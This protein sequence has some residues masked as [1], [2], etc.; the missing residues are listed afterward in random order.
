ME[1]IC[2]WIDG[3]KNLKNVF[4]TLNAQYTCEH[5]YDED[6]K[7]LKLSIKKKKDYYNIFPDN[8]NLITI[9]GANGCGKSSII[10]AITAIL[11]NNT[12][13]ECEYCLIMKNGNDFIYKKSDNITIKNHN[14]QVRKIKI[15]TVNGYPDG[16]VCK[17]L[18]F[19]PFLEE[20]FTGDTKFYNS[21]DEEFKIQDQINNYFFYDRFQESTVAFTISRGLNHLKK[22]SI[23]QGEYKNILFEK[24]GWEFNVKDCYNHMVLRLRKYLRDTQSNNFP[25]SF[26]IVL[27]N[28]QTYY[29]FYELVNRIKFF[30]S[31]KYDWKP[32]SVKIEDTVQEIIFF[33]GICQF[34][35]FVDYVEKCL[36]H[37]Y[38]QEFEAN[39]KN[40]IKLGEID[41]RKSAMIEEI[42]EQ[43]LSGIKETQP[44]EASLIAK[45]ITVISDKNLKYNTIINV[46]K[47]KKYFIYELN[48]IKN[49][50]ENP[51]ILFDVLNK[52]FYIENFTY[53]INHK[54]RPLIENFLDNEIYDENTDDFS[55]IYINKYEKRI[56]NEAI[57]AICKILPQNFTSHY[58]HINLYKYTDDVTC[59]TFKDM[60]T[61]EQRLIKFFAD[62]FYCNPR[63]I[64][65]I[66]EIDMSWHP[67]WYRKLIFSILEVFSAEKF[68]GKFINIILTTHS[69]IPLSDLPANNIISLKKSPK[70]SC[71]E[72]Y[73]GLNKTFAANIHTL[74]ANQFFLES[75]I[76]EYA[77]NKIKS[78]I[79][80]LSDDKDKHETDKGQNNLNLKNLS[81]RDCK[82]YIEIIGE[83]VYK[84]IL[85]NLY[86]RYT[87]KKG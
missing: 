62:I 58:F 48:K 24:F 86:K 59:Y 64:Y 41:A 38:A 33:S 3:Y 4:L 26:P 19:K 82:K 14:F 10:N 83:E 39:L 57:D 6:Q 76:G 18:S 28:N 42:F 74:F 20:N 27:H 69:P 9:V 8:I 52:Y 71:C 16:D 23:F 79:C 34:G 46:E 40:S 51:A 50:M 66:D 36:K 21:Y 63:D 72:K 29:E 73:D 43:I 5:K 77:E 80:S 84:K 68:R 55:A 70:N 45:L 37:Y 49:I 22:L 2:L 78:I 54:N 35:F 11:R 7:S 1:L 60:S 25:M 47:E 65:L 44:L 32:D 53:K 61:G 17:V 56:N 67:E 12:F 30:Q 81:V 31:D 13:N 75:T 87:Q 85:Y 15:K